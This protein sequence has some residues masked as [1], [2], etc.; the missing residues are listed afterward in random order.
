MCLNISRTASYHKKIFLE[1][2][3][4]VTTHIVTQKKKEREKT[5]QNKYIIK[6]IATVISLI[7]VILV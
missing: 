7:H 3:M 1:I 6:I 5:K 2:H 4:T